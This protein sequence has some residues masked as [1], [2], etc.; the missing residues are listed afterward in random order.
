MGADKVVEEHVGPTNN[1]CA[2]LGQSHLLQQLPMRK[3]N[4]WLLF[5]FP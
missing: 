4:E 2:I 3:E 1:A 5:I